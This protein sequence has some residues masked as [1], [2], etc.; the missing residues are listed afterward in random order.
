MFLAIA[1]ALL[2]FTWLTWRDFRFGMSLF[3]FLLPTYL[4]RFSIGPVP[5]TV[6]EL[7]FVIIF[8]RWLFEKTSVKNVF[9]SII[10]INKTPFF[11]PGILLLLGATLSVFSASE[12]LPALG[13]WKAYFIEPFLFYIILVDTLKTKEDWKRL[14]IALGCLVIATSLLSFYQA[15]TGLLLPTWEWSIEET[16]RA[17][18]FF[19]SPNALG[20]LV[21]PILILF[22]G[23][24]L[25]EDKN[26]TGKN[27]LRFFQLL[28]L[29]FGATAIRYSLSRGAMIAIVVGVLY[30]LWQACS[31]KGVM[32]ISAGLLLVAI[33]LPSLRADIVRIASFQVESGQSRIALYTG[34]TQLLKQSPVVGL[35]LASFADKFEEV[36]VGEFTEKLIYP[37][38]I[39]LNFWSETGIIGLI[40]LVWIIVLI[41]KI[42]WKQKSFTESDL[43]ISA[44]LV[45]FI[46]GLVDVNYF[47]NDLA[48]LTWLTL[49]GLTYASLS[50]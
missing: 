10:A 2:T 31:K 30:L 45:M 50:E 48:M 43:F 7:L 14:F 24:F 8:I 32:I 40:A 39:F 15:Y 29:L 38:N 20:L 47:K 44:L 23:W 34:T 12:V 49:A 25:L 46:H 35:G 21:G 1:I 9:S 4:L 42:A 3:V 27:A 13:I 5:T 41:V 17:T 16:R 6:L 37:H 28:I 11:W 19:T 18:S 33:L 26:K 22:F 36:R